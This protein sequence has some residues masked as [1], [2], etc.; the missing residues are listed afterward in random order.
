M[1]FGLTSKRPP[2]INHARRATSDSITR[3]AWLRGKTALVTAVDTELG[4]ET[5]RI[6][7]LRGAQV[8]ATAKTRQ[9]AKDACAL[10]AGKTRPFACDFTDPQSV[11]DAVSKIA[12]F[13]KPIDIVVCDAGTGQGEQIPSPSQG[14][15]APALPAN[16]LGQFALINGLLDALSVADQGRLVIVARPTAAQRLPKN[17]GQTFQAHAQTVA[18]NS[19]AGKPGGDKQAALLKNADL[20]LMK[21]LARRT[22]GTSVTVN[23]VKPGAIRTKF[24]R[25]KGPVSAFLSEKLGPFVARTAAHA[26]ASQCYVATSPRLKRV[27]GYYFVTCNKAPLDAAARDPRLADTFWRQAEQSLDVWLSRPRDVIEPATEN[28]E[29]I[30]D[31]VGINNV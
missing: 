13:D 9:A 14:L 15:G 8:L 26:A 12:G 28:I 21:A 18:G 22:A 23:A 19:S 3:D 16:K 30:E 27:S 25:F 20:L 24:L 17:E 11:A 7:S 29:N 1:L 31:F 10:I 5:M 2:K 4:F 6:L